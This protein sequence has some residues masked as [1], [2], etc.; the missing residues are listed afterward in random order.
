MLSLG[1]AGAWSRACLMQ[2]SMSCVRSTLVG[3]SSGA[4]PGAGTGDGVAGACGAGLGP[5][6]AGP[7]QN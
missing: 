3:A 1:P 5:G 6:D 7:G 4:G 2:V